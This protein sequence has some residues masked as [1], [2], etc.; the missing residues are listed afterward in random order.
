[1]DTCHVADGD[2]A[3]DTDLETIDLGGRAGQPTRRGWLTHRP[4]V[5]LS[6][7]GVAFVA[8]GSLSLAAVRSTH[9]R[10]GTADTSDTPTS[11]STRPTTG[12]IQPVRVRPLF[13]RTSPNG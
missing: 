6:V 3:A 13:T 12:P 10:G 1:M 2:D 8:I 11:V 5:V 7:L 4:R 9:H